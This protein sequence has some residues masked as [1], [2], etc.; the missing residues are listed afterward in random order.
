MAHPTLSSIRLQDLYR[1]LEEANPDAVIAW[2]QRH[3][4]LASA[5]L[6]PNCNNTMELANRDGNDGK[7]WICPRPCN[8]RLSIRHGTFFERS[9]LPIRKII[10][11]VYWWAYELISFKQ[12]KHEIGMS[13]H[14]FVDWKMF[15]RDICAEYFVINPLQLG[16]PNITVEI[17][18]SVFTRRKYNRGRLTME[19]W[20]FGGIDTT[21]RKGFLIPVDRRD[22]NTLL[23]II[24]DFIL[25]GTTVVSDCWSSYNT[26]GNIGYTHLTVNHSVNFV[27]PVT[28]AHKNNVENM[29]M[30]AKRR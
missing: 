1:D 11:F 7:R 10:I 29:W 12:V 13:Q 6:C 15:L 17:D 5:K 9:N 23:P 3:G 24:Q 21:T 4:L 28:H 22:A 26:V 14:T 25:P 8:T 19:Q 16:G 20:V 2:C 27:D 18:E 30:R